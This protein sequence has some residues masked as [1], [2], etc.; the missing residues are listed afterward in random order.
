MAIDQ[1]LMMGIIFIIAGV[2]LALLAYA[3][4]LYRKAPE[5]GEAEDRIEPLEE[6]HE[7]QTDAEHSPDRDQADPQNGEL[8]GDGETGDTDATPELEMDVSDKPEPE[9]EAG[10]SEE[11]EPLGEA[12]DDMPAQDSPAL[13]SRGVAVAAPLE[14]QPPSELE[15]P[16]PPITLSQNSETGRLDVQIGD[17]T[18]ATA[19]ELRN[20]EEWKRAAPLLRDT[21]AWLTMADAHDEEA[22]EPTD[23][24]APEGPYA[25]PGSIVE[26]I[27]QILQKKLSRTDS[28]QRAVRLVE[29]SGGAI[30]VYV[31]VS[32]YS[33]EEVPDAEVRRL[34]REAVAEWEAQQ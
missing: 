26:Q 30:R 20:S 24:P 6:A 9:P 28:V 10:E 8:D 29:G 4:F 3:A 31:G 7:D 19:Q 17:R 5:E 2:A 12:V 18:F 15:G 14:P 16:P 34:I 33:M 21:V 32:S 13:K 22:P 11:G 25:K 1:R 27:D 23:S